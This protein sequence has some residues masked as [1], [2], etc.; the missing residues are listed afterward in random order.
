[1]R[2]ACAPCMAPERLF[3][4]ATPGSPR[5]GWAWQEPQ[6]TGLLVSRWVPCIWS[7]E[8]R[9]AVATLMPG[10]VWQRSQLIS[11]DTG[12]TGL[13]RAILAPD[14]QTDISASWSGSDLP[15]S[16]I[17][18]M[19]MPVTSQSMI[20]LRA[21]MLPESRLPVRPTSG[22]SAVPNRESA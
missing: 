5:G 19:G 4:P 15:A 16:V 12:T 3:T 20:S 18:V 14:C 2:A 9:M 11:H 6:T 21:V 1:M 10:L 17:W 22:G 8:R 13:V 7:C